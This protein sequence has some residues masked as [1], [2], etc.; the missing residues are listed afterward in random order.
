MKNIHCFQLLPSVCCQFVPQCRL[1]A[2]I[3]SLAKQIQ[4]WKFILCNN[5]L[6]NLEHIES[7]MLYPVKI[8][9]TK[10][11]FVEQLYYPQA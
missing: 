10:H 7:S 11:W 6:I 8:P 2:S 3:H 1:F 5:Q 9:Y 4:G